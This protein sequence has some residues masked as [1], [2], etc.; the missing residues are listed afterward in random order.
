[1]K[2]IVAKAASQPI[3]QAKWLPIR[4]ERLLLR[5]F[6]ARD[7]AAIHE[8]ASDPE[9]SRWMDWGPNTPEIT[10]RVLAL[11]LR[12][13]SQRPPGKIELAIELKAE[14]KLIGGIRLEIRD[15]QNRT[16]DFGYVLHKNYWNRGLATEAS[17]AILELAF[18]KWRL[19]RVWATC[20]QRNHA[21]YRVMEKLGMRREGSYRQD[22]F[23]KG[24]WRNSY[25]YAILAD[26]WNNS[27]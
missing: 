11:R 18:A 1:M 17:R 12:M 14:K 15:Q 27:R 25:L 19:H 5:E 4:T 23:Q 26:D 10:R 7:E 20:D 9:V 21:S 22:V 2:R 3:L 24:E 16:A 8:Y 13:Q 6:R